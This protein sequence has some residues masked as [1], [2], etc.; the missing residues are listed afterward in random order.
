MPTNTTPITPPQILLEWSAP[1]LPRHNRSPRWYMILGGI[2][3]GTA[4]YGIITSAWSVTIVTVLIGC[5]EFLLRGSDP[6]VKH[7]SL[8]EHGI[9]LAGAFTRWE[10][11]SSFWLIH[12]P[13]YT[14]LHISKRDPRARELHIQVE[15]VDLQ[16]VRW[17]LARFLS[18]DTQQ[19]EKMIDIIIRICKL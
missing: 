16:D 8:T 7:I 14:R 12:T 15:N 19:M 18:E 11:C 3:L 1:I 2:V 6:P 17:T 9:V 13:Q 10:D 5:M 4:A